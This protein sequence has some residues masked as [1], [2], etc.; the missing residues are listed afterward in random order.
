MTIAA[1]VALGWTVVSAA[2]VS[3][4]TPS[5][6]P[7]AAGTP[8]GSGFGYSM[9]LPPGWQVTL[10]SG[11]P[12]GGEDLFEGPDGVSARVGGGPADPSHTVQERVAANREELTGD[13]TCQSDPS[14][15][16]PTTLGGEPAIAWSWTC[17]DSYH[18]AV[19]TL[20]DGLRLRLQVNVPL[21]AQAS[22]AALL[23]AF[24]WTFTFDAPADLVALEQMLQGSYETPWHPMALELA[25]I[26]AAGLDLG[27]DP[28]VK[29][30]F[31]SI[32]EVRHVI[33]FAD[34]TM[35]EYCAA[36]GE[37]LEICWSAA[38]RLVDDKTIEATEIGRPTTRMLYT[39]TLR[40]GILTLDVVG[41]DDPIDLIAQVAIFETLPF[42]RVP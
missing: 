9:T 16:A 29:D 11:D 6:S 33:K 3:A 2:A 34:G 42:T 36:D 39:F 27:D 8:F 28:P 14:G 20:R 18:A 30:E 26:E 21:E 38:Y 7:S 15:D 35:S 24:R 1:V 17:P 13:G 32:S 23:E 4:A 19:N 12:A 22:A 37:P 31:T 41:A 5:A 40:D 25:A 10:A